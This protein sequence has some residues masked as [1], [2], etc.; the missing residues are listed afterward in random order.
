MACYGKH[1]MTLVDNLSKDNYIFED[2]C[3]DAE[4]YRTDRVNHQIIK[5]ALGSI[6]LNQNV[7]YYKFPIFMMVHYIMSINVL[8]DAFTYEDLKKLVSN[9]YA[10]AFF[11]VS[12]SKSKNK[13]SIDQT[14]FTELYKIDEGVAANEVVHGIIRATQN[15]RRCYLDEYVQ[16]N[17][18]SSE[19]AYALYSLMDNYVARNNYI[20]NIYCFPEYNVEHLIAHNNSNLTII[21]NELNNKFS[22]SL[23]ELLGSPDGKTY[24]ATK[25]RKTTANYLIIPSGLNTDLEK[26][27]I[28][29]KI[30]IIR[31]HYNRHHIDI[32]KHV[33]II[34]SHIEQQPEYNSLKALKGTQKTEEEIKEAYKNFVNA[35]F[36]DEQQHILYESLQSALRSAFENH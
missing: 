3:S 18:F 19:K 31:E 13:S 27:D 7:Q 28:V 16:F 34:L 14:I 6:I 23:K 17:I 21:W 10:Y 11:F 1:I 32:P 20:G 12:N 26:N 15:L 4:R 5:R 24:K 8:K 2:L 29:K 30:E 22:F 25:Y 36:S 9:Y 35:Y 33:E